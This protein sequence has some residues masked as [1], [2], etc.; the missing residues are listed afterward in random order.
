MQQQQQ[1]QSQNSKLVIDASGG[2]YTNILQVQHF[3]QKVC[4]NILSTLDIY[5]QQGQQMD[6]LGKLLFKNSDNGCV[7]FF[8][9]MM[10]YENTNTIVDNRQVADGSSANPS[11]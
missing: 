5:Q 1:M 2:V 6:P 11:Q 10:Y 3:C 9:V 8:K 7:L 4:P